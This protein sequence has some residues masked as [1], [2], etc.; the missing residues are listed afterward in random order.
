MGCDLSP[1]PLSL[2][3]MEYNENGFVHFRDH[4]LSSARNMSFTLTQQ[5]FMR[6]VVGGTRIDYY[7]IIYFYYYD[8]HRNRN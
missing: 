5:S 2:D 3:S 7:L 8:Y 4:F 6:A 1:I